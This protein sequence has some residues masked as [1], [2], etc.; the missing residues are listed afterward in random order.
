MN[1]F[2]YE[3][4]EKSLRIRLTALEAELPL[5][6][7]DKFIME[8]EGQFETSRFAIPQIKIAVS[9]RVLMP[10][11]LASCIVVFLVLLIRFVN[12][13]NP[14]TTITEQPATILPEASEL[15]PETEFLKTDT[16]KVVAPVLPANEPPA[17]ASAPVTTA[18]AAAQTPQ[19]PAVQVKSPASSTQQSVHYTGR[20]APRK[21]KREEDVETE[22]LPDIRPVLTTEEREPE[23]KFN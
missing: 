18:A 19:N 7:W 10:V 11:A 4:D 8:S 21:Q 1:H 23:I 3:I 20:A 13:H 17:M 22:R 9:R 16:E 12:I 2:V 14:P 15:N 5:D 6:A